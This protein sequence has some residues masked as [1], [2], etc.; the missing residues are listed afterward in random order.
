MKP[1]HDQTR[2]EL[3]LTITILELRVVIGEYNAQKRAEQ[4]ESAGLKPF[5]SPLSLFPD[6]LERGRVY[7][8]SEKSLPT[9]LGVF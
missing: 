2:D 3:L 9:Q 4:L 1:V 6:A 8:D 7:S 5:T